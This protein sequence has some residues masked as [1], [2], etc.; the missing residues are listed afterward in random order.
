M[1]IFSGYDA[2]NGY[3]PLTGTG[4]TLIPTT[5]AVAGTFFN[6]NINGL[7][8]TSVSSYPSSSGDITT[9]VTPTSVVPE[10]SSVAPVLFVLAGVGMWRCRRP[11]VRA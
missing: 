3:N 4:G 1:V 2:V 8:A 5:D 6:F 10:P 7:G 11:R 9:T